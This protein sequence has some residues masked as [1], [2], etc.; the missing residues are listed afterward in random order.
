M[1]KL[2]V[3]LLG[4]IS[5]VVAF[6]QQ[7]IGLKAGAAFSNPSHQ[8]AIMPGSQTEFDSPK[9][10]PLWG[11]SAGVF[12]KIKVAAHWRLSVEPGLLVA[13][14][15]ERFL[16]EE[17]IINGD[18][19]DHYC[20]RQ[21]GY[22]E[23]PAYLQYDLKRFYFS[24]GAGISLKVFSVMKGIENRRYNSPFYRTCDAGINTLAGYHLLQRMDVNLRYY[25]GL[26]NIDKAGVS[27]TIRN[28]IGTLTL[29]YSLNTRRR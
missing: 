6:T 7:S 27:K 17:Q 28:R 20:T 1:K 10:R 5:G 24:G 3:L 9:G 22:L 14:R 16:T 13:G 12:Y 21:V 11:Y 15:Q 26:A 23:I 19:G 18:L 29:L 25:H 8:P 2:I 4:C